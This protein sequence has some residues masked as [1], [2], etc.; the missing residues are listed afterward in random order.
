MH[1]WRFVGSLILDYSDDLQQM[2]IKKGV[3]QSNVHVTLLNK[4]SAKVQTWDLI[5]GQF[6]NSCFIKKVNNIA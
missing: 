4:T 2:Y 3:L 1:R 6:S 5:Q